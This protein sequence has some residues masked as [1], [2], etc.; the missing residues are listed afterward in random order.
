MDFLGIGAGE[1]LLI[2]V[3]GILIMDPGKLIEMTKSLGKFKRKVNTTCT[4][5]VSGVKN[6]LDSV[7]KIPAGDTD[8]K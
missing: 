5:L 1:L 6:E 7:Q 4:D 8:K 2:L 3:L